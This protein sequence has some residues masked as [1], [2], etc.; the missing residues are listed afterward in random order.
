MYFDT[1]ILLGRKSSISPINNNESTYAVMTDM[2][3]Q[4]YMIRHKIHGKIKKL[5]SAQKPGAYG[6]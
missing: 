3:S 1:D 4:I 5:P 2:V 6:N